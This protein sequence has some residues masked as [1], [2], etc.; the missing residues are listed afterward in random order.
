MEELSMKKYVIGADVGGTTVKLGFFTRDGELLDKWEIPT[1]VSA[2]GNIIQDI[3]DSCKK[4]MAECG[5]ALEDFEGIGIGVPGPVLPDGTAEGCVNIGW[6]R[7]QVKEE[8]EQCLGLPAVCGNDANMA[9]LGEV[10]KGSA[11][12][13]DHAVMVTLGTGVGGGIIVSGKMIGGFH[14]CGGE[15]GHLIINAHET[16]KCNCG[17]AGCL[18][19]Y[20]S[21]TGIVN[22]TKKA[23][24][25][26]R[27][28]TSLS[29]KA[30][31]DAKDI[32]DAA[33]AG[34]TF[35]KT[36]VDLF[37]KRLAKALS[38]IAVVVDPEIVVIGGGVSNAG[39]I[40]TDNVAKHY[41]EDFAFGPQ[42]DIRFV[43]AALGNDAGIY[44]CAKAVISG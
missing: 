10:W 39:S 18:E 36:Q 27:S 22:E 30:S 19:Q 34:D 42:K 33:Q 17:K 4:K 5:Y 7:K 32:F 29:S 2:Q 1:D 11:S 20:C 9:A 38:M 28:W 41:K 43:L 25:K 26:N 40:I 24:R 8:V 23:M 31:F 12:G 35:A 16:V 15:I 3:A 6:G 13:H 44:G 14:G 21:A 37:C